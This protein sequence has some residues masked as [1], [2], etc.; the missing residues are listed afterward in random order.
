MSMESTIFIK[1]NNKK[2]KHA[3]WDHESD[4]ERV[5]LGEYIEVSHYLQK[6]KKNLIIE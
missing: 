3:S 2:K 1:Q 5:V 4:H 6:K